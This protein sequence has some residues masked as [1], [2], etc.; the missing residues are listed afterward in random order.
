MACLASVLLPTWRAPFTTTTR[1][2]GECLCRHPFRV[3]RV[4]ILIIAHD[5]CILALHLED[6]VILPKGS[7]LI[8]RNIRG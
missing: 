6:A 8:C 4:Q 7:W 2:S 3:A 1:V 5:G